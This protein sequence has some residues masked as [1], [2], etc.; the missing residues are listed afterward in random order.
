MS[1]EGGEE[2]RMGSTFLLCLSVAAVEL[3]RY[4]LA[5]SCHSGGHWDTG[6]AKQ[7]QSV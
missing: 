5:T 6:G 7:V 1:V 2:S 4:E 3:K